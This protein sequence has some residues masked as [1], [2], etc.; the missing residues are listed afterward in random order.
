M[1]TSSAP[2][3]VFG[4]TGVQGRPVV[5]R[6]LAE[7]RTVRAVAKTPEKL[8]ALATAGAEIHPL[9]L[10]DRDALERVF[11]GAGGA[12]V[13]LPYVM[14]VDEPM[15]LDE[16]MRLWASTI[17]EAL[18]STAV[19]V[20]VFSSS[21]PVPS[22][23]TGLVTFDSKKAADEALRASGAPLVFLRPAIYLGNLAAPFSAPSVVERDELRYPPVPSDV[24]LPYISVEDQAAAAVAALDRSDLIGRTLPIGLM[25]SGAHLAR[26]LTAG[27]GREITHAP[28]TPG[29]LGD[30]V[31]P[32]MG[33]HVAEIIAADYV[34]VGQRPA[35][36]NLDADVDASHRELGVTTTPV[37]EWAAV[38]DWQGAAAFA[39]GA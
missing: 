36:L 32:L 31:R 13:H 11:A 23:L 15:R 18:R 34:L 3:V 7:G 2:V 21:G 28:M 12:F 9:D 37:A 38:Q 19:P 6:L 29:E 5:D 26:E 22:Q 24:Q 16:L 1:T 17:G 39:A 35:S 8:E 4:A 33:N 14:P 10:A 25:L 20:A 27:L 30:S